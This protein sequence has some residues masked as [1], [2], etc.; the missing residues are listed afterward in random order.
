MEGFAGVVSVGLMGWVLA[1]LGI[2]GVHLFRVA[3]V[4]SS[5]RK[6]FRKGL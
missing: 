3:V 6:I 4:K 2:V 5:D 1:G